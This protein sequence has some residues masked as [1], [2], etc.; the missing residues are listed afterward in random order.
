LGQRISIG[1]GIRNW[2]KEGRNDPLKKEENNV[3][4]LNSSI[5]SILEAFS[6]GLRRIIKFKLE[7]NVHW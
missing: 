6:V 2:V 1:L 4:V 5:F 3:Y 7:I